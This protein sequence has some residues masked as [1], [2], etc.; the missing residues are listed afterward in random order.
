MSDMPLILLK[1]V[2]RHYPS[3]DGFTTVLRNVDL[4]IERGEM[5]AIVGASGSGK[6][7]LM[8][9]LGCLDRPSE[10]QYL[11]SGRATA[12]LTPDELAQLRREHFGFIFQR[13]H[14][15]NELDAVGNVEIPAIYAGQAHD[16]RRESAHG[17]LYRLGMGDRTH[18]RPNQ[19]SGGQ[20]QRVSIA[21]A[22]I[23]DADVI[24]A[25]E[26]TGA[27]DSHSG[28]EVLGILQEP[29]REGR[30]IIIVTHDR[31]VAA[32][33]NRIIEIRDGEIIADASREDGYSVA[34]SHSP[35]ASSM[36][37]L[38]SFSGIRDRFKE[39]FA[40]ALRSMNAHRMRTFLTM[41]G[42]II[43]T[44][45]VV[46]VTALGQGSQQRILEQISSLGTNTLYIG[47]GSGYGDLKAALVTTLSVDDSNELAKLPYVVAA[48]PESTTA[49]TVR[50][51]NKEVSITV[52]GVSEQYFAT[53]KSKLI[54]GRYFDKKGLD[55]LAQDAVIDTNA[56][57][58]LFPN[59]QGSVVGK[60]LFLKQIPVRIVGVT[61][62]D[63]QGMAGSSRLELFLPYTTV[64]TRMTGTR[65]L[66]SIAVRI[67][68]TMDPAV[69]E[70]MV[71]AFLTRRHG[72]EDFFIFNSDTLQKT[73]Q[74]TT[75]MLALLVASI[76][77]ISLFVGGI[78]VMNIM[79]VA[80]SERINEIG[81]R[82]AV[83]ARQSDILQQFLIESILVCL[84]GGV[85]GVL[86]AGG[87]GLLFAQFSTKIQLIYSPISIVVA[88]LC[89]SLIGIGFGFMPARN[90]S[91]LDPV[92][93]LARD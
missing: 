64:Q 50:V 72:K 30:T 83:G 51:G 32:R 65:T 4:T 46:C 84:I 7:T 76:A 87:F 63:D 31:A 15:M 66:Q 69:A 93:A 5:V 33:A 55:N 79:L 73:I 35:M 20:Q 16:E 59:E 8:N 1:N 92:V 38:K 71:K 88:L 60:I 78:G 9:I 42:I 11:I 21:R 52:N 80:V 56:Q 86:I 68:D 39:A 12:E 17:I 77:G 62:A 45:S 19:L 34:R 28:E 36:Q 67:R 13:Y 25:D 24:L 18:H 43:G 40:M 37:K 48:T 53:R 81:V 58:G 85:L 22:L 14:L 6:S 49:G 82:M 61:K 3:G 44:A 29:N 26:P 90:A 54:E 91:R 70:E 2:S 89:S 57:K 41:L 27:L 23:N 47:P 74:A 75:A 10:G